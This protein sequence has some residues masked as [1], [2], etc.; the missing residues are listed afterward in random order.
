[1]QVQAVE[2]RQAEE[3]VLQPAKQGYRLKE[4]KNEEPF[5]TVAMERKIS[6]QLNT[7]VSIEVRLCAR[8]HECHLWV[9][10]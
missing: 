4:P 9:G 2:V 3:V 5:L 10:V 1:M 7:Q 8:V 6:S